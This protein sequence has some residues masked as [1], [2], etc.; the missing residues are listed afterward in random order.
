M[1]ARPLPAQSRPSIVEQVIRADVRTMHAYAVP[2]ATGF[3]KLDAM[4]NPFGLPD[5]LRSDLARRLA[6]LA[7]NRYPP[8]R[9]D[10]LRATL[11]RV[12]KVPPTCDVLLG[13]GSDELISLLCIAV[14]RDGASVLSL[15]PG[16]AM[17]ALSTAF[18]RLAHVQ[19]ALRPD[20]TLDRDA[21]VAAL[22]AHRPALAFIAYPNNPTGNRFERADVE[23]VIVA[24]R[25]TDTLVVVDEAYRAFA[26]DSFMPDLPRHDNLLVLRTVSKSGLAGVRLGYLCGPSAWLD[27]L[28]K[29]RPPYNINV[30]TQCAATFALEHVDVLDAQA[31][32][33]RVER[34][35]LM[36]A[37]RAIDG[38]EPFAS[39]ANFIL[40]RVRGDDPAVASAVFEALKRRR[41]L[42]KDL[43]R[44]HPLCANAL[45]VTVSTPDENAVF[46]DALVASLQEVSATNSPQ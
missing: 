38:I 13:N 21:T 41:V 34:E 7:V 37:L 19:V 2:D 29:V 4:E 12:M 11:R 35:R 3:V 15:A 42:I 17:F 39:Q 28:D 1:S 32:V 20:F 30:L 36:D 9:A 14:A 24:A 18:A 40:F 23:A 16:F 27:E 46:V 44:S 31:A 33:L 5:A 25:A 6:E 26:S 45:R 8:P 43:S 22:R 10:A